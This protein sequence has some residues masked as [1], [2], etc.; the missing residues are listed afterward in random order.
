MLTSWSNVTSGLRSQ[1]QTRSL[2]EH[3]APHHAYLVG[4]CCR[5]Q[6]CLFQRPVTH[7]IVQGSCTLG[8]RNQQQTTVPP[9]FEHRFSTWSTQFRYHVKTHCAHI[10][11]WMGFNWTKG[12][13]NCSFGSNSYYTN[14]WACAPLLWEAC[15][16]NSACLILRV[17]PLRWIM[18]VA[19]VESQ[20]SICDGDGFGSNVSPKEASATAVSAPFLCTLQITQRRSQFHH[21]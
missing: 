9:R 1:D 12:S 2:R 14:F 19:A 18:M 7:V 20:Q 3:T 10:D 11:M 21:H 16:F 5:D 15:F 17:E 6:S 13:R 8:A 4:G